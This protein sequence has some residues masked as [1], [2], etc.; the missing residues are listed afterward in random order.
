[1]YQEINEIVSTVIHYWWV[2][3][4]IGIIIAIKH[5]RNT[6]KATIIYQG[7][8]WAA[9]KKAVNESIE[10]N[11]EIVTSKP[12]IVKDDEGGYIETNSQNTSGN[13]VWYGIWKIGSN[14]ED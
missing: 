11:N 10:N 7:E 2:F 9:A 1:M 13:F 12:K 6:D 4:L 14:K 5:N 3:A 8:S